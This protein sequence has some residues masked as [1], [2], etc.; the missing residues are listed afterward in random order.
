MPQEKCE[1]D[2]VN[3]KQDLRLRGTESP[4]LTKDGEPAPKSSHDLMDTFI[5][6]EVITGEYR[7]VLD[8]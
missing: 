4:M 6:P 2:D 7:K 1:N 8:S 3:G 5:V